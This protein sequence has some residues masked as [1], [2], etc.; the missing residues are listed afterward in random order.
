MSR[1]EA[2]GEAFWL[3]LISR[4]R[5][6][7]RRPPGV[8]SAI[9]GSKPIERPS[10]PKVQALSSS[11]MITAKPESSKSKIA[12][13]ENSTAGDKPAG[14]PPPKVKR[15]ASDIFKSL[16]KSKTKPKLRAEE[17][18]TSVE[19]AAVSNAEDSVSINL[20]I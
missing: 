5:R 11:G 12:A 13:S 6:T 14:K 19:S 9:P 20:E 4:Q 17:T 10:T 15:E 18:S 3:A 2:L 7:G 16:S 1:Y 8:T